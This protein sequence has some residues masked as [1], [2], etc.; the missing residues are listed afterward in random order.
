L[1]FV[2]I[3]KMSDQ[4][5]LIPDPQQEPTISVAVAAEIAGVA[6]RTGYD[7]VQRGEWPSVR[8]G[9]CVRIRTREFL[10]QL[11]LLD[12][13]PR[14]T[15]KPISVSVSEAIDARIDELLAQL[16]PLTDEQCRAA[17]AI[18]A[19]ARPRRPRTAEGGAA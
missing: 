1:F 16:P 3:K 4:I 17:A 19:T 11:G 14:V 10:H 9:R 2:S 6:R 12:D 13:D 8:V 15:A 18:F 7:A 5:R